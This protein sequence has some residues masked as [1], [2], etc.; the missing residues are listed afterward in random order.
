MY[1]KTL[2]CAIHNTIVILNINFIYGYRLDAMGVF[3]IEKFS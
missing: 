1:A 2:Y 3:I